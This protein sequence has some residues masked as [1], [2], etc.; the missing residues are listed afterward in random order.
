MKVI[1]VKIWL[2][3]LLLLSATFNALAQSSGDKLFMEGQKLQQTQTVAAQNQAIKKFKSAKVV[4]TTTDKKKMCDNQIAI[5]NNNITSLK[6]RGSKKNKRSL[7][8]SPTENKVSFAV[9]Q[10]HVQFDG[11]KNGSVVVNVEAPSL[12][13]AFNLPEGIDGET[14]FVEVSKSSDSLSL[15]IS[16][17]ANPTTIARTQ[18][19][20]VTHG[21]SVKKIVVKQYGKDVNFSGSTSLLKFGVKGGSKS[22]ELYTNSDFTVTTNNNLTWYVESK[23]VWVE[24]SVE[25]KKKKGIVGKGISAIKGLVEG[26]AEAASAEDVKTSNIK[27]VA[28]PLI[29]SDKEYQTGRRGEIIFASQDK[30][31]KVIV[32]QQN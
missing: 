3:T 23:P 27:V 18:T 22:F 19:I 4:Y 25:A 20:N 13:W 2:T 5:C 24:V 6:K 12:E 8:S 30:K 32:V 11:E 16:A 17:K 1:V 28:V 15:E 31:Y 26:K 14:N 10:N 21:S 29:K 7:D 9:S